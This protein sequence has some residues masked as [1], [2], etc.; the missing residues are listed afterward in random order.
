M[1]AAA[2]AGADAGAAA[3][4]ATPPTEKSPRATPPL[5]PPPA[6]DGLLLVGGSLPSAR[7][8]VVAACTRAISSACLE[9]SKWVCSKDR[10]LFVCLFFLSFLE[11][12][13]FFNLFVSEIRRKKISID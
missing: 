13:F 4:A 10:S 12:V 3:A 2:A 5:P 9:A 6:E 1:A 11:V 7:I 8:A